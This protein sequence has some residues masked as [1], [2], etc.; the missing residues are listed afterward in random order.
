MK[1]VAAENGKVS[2]ASKVTKASKAKKLPEPAKKNVSFKCST[3]I[4]IFFFI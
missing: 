4:V 1:K 3:K 2:K